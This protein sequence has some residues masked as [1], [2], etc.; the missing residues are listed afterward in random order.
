M[1]QTRKERMNL[2]VT[3]PM[4]QRNDT[5]PYRQVSVEVVVPVYN[6]ETTLP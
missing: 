6:E 2:M 5:L 3:V 4:P 1:I